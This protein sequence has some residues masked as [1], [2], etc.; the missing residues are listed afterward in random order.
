MNLKKSQPTA[1]D[2]TGATE[3]GTATSKLL[4]VGG[5]V[6]ALAGAGALAFVLL[7][8][9]DDIPEGTAALPKPSAAA[10]SPS[11]TAGTP[12]TSASIPTYAAK[13]ARDPFKALVTEPKGGGST[14]G[15]SSS[16]GGSGTAPTT[17]P[18]GGGSGGGGGIITLP[19][20]T[21]TVTQTVTPSSNPT[22][23][24]TG[25][26]TTTDTQTP[27]PTG[28]AP[29]VEV[30]H[31]TQ[32]LSI[33]DI[34]K[35]ADGNPVSVTVIVDNTP[36]E[37]LTPQRDIDPAKWQTFGTY[38]TLLNLTDTTA[39]IR[40]GDGRVFDVSLGYYYVVQS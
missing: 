25:Y 28:T 22:T 17:A 38:Y 19:G 7:S 12:S 9:G 23:A 1:D 33:A 20:T 27:L 31:G 21:V 30:P 6:V 29:T 8:G 37:G 13:N 15:G 36:Y 4:L 40:Y 5:G 26:P 14:G 24:P 10:P 18:G 35:D 32:M 11:E 34:T 16:G 39:T 2:T 3:S